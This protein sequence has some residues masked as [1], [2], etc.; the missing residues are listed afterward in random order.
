MIAAINGYALG[1]GM[2]LALSADLR[3]LADDA[4]LGQP[5]IGRCDP[6]SGGHQRTH[7]AR[8]SSRSAE[9]VYTGRQIDA[10]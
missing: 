1:G 8:R 10:Q 6:R 7:E 4:R 3:L 9:L 5:E 2:E